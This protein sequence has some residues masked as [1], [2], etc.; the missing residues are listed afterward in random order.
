MH[1]ATRPGLSDCAG[2]AAAPGT[3][4]AE[5]ASAEE[6]RSLLRTLRLQLQEAIGDATAKEASARRMQVQLEIMQQKLQQRE[7]ELREL[8]D[9]TSAPLL[10]EPAHECV[11]RFACAAAPMHTRRR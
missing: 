11:P 1:T 10:S 5:A 7:G 2:D 3:P 4:G 8:Q 6:A 9:K